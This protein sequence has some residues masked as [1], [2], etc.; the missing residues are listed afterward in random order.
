MLAK[1]RL[2]SQQ[3]LINELSAPVIKL[4]RHIGL[5]PVVGEIDTQR[6]KYILENT[7]NECSKQGITHLHIDLSE[8]NMIDTMVA[9]EI[10]RL[11][12]ALKI[13]G[14][15]TTLSGVRP[16]FALT[17]VHLGLDFKNIQITGNLSQALQLK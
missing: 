7:L 2:R 6:A 10:F 12:D 9:M 4:Q 16:E 13:V 17:A 14:V 1:K 3:E 8:V 11:I 15:K 5:L